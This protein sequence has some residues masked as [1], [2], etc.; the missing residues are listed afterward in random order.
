MTGPSNAVVGELDEPMRLPETNVPQDV[1]A[2][3]TKLAKYSRT[4]EFKRLKEFLE[5]RIK[6]FQTFLPDGTPVEAVKMGSTEMVA[7]W[8]AA[9]VIIRE[10]NN[11]LGEY[12]RAAEVVKDGR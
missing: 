3:E 8:I 2:E 4:A 11:V 6:F 7:H 10:F 1:L 9:N 12:E 5:N